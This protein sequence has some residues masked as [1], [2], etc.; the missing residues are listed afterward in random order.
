MTEDSS[1]PHVAIPPRSGCTGCAG[2][3]RRAFLNTASVISLGALM[4]ACGDGVLSG[5]ESFLDI[6]RDPIRI[7]PRLYPELQTVGGRVTIT[8]AGRAPMVVEHTGAQQFRAYSL[9]CPHKGTVVDLT[10]TGFTCPNHGATFARDGAWTGGQST[11]ALS[12]IAVTIE[13]D[14]ALLVGG[15][16]LPP[17]PPV[18]ALSASNVS[19]SATIGG[20][21]PPSQVINVTNSGGGTLTGIAFT[22]SYA[23]NQPTGWLGV[24]LSS[25]AAPATLTL[26]V[27]RGALSAGTYSANIQ[28]SGANASGGS[29]TV[30]VTLVVIDTTTP[31]A[32]QLSTTALT[33]SASVGSSPAPQTVQIINSGSGTVGALAVSVVYGAGATGW[34][35]TSSLSGTSTP[36]A[37]TVRPLSAS[38]AAGT[39]TATVSVSGA[40]VT[41]RQ[42]AVTLVVAIDGLAVTI[43]D[44]P[45]LANVGGVAGSV[46]SLN[47]N[48]IA[49]V[50]AGANS[51]AAFSL[52]C[53]HAQFYVQVVGGQSFRCP[54]HGALFNANGSL[55]NNSPIQTGSLTPMRVSYTPGAPILYVSS[56]PGRSLRGSAIEPPPRAG[57]LSR[58]RC[59]SFPIVQV[60]IP[61]RLTS[62]VAQTAPS[63]NGS[64]RSLKSRAR[65][66]RPKA[67]AWP[68]A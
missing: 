16:V 18:L 13:P 44:W 10:T 51:F 47:F 50:R 46:G 59:S 19:F 36:S 20:A 63:S 67:T 60:S 15:I 66:H 35:S 57:Y 17:S 52:I 42:L 54:N 6:V 27:T 28:V 23:A 25:L 32:I 8:P 49:V 34:L 22:L 45:A 21:A 40:G 29:R 62:F 3:D 61:C 31:P 33:F 2:L 12:P 58:L 7:D 14:G 65:S 9:I 1:T 26:S 53:P 24:T 48:P 43:A 5:P 30:T 56:G 4:A 68:C 38:L 64:S 37:L 11:V 41:T 39:Y 55:A